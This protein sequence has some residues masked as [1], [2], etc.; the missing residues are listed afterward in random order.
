M[1]KFEDSLNL[2]M[3]P[4]DLELLKEIYDSLNKK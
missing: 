4:G 2:K 3:I 1:M